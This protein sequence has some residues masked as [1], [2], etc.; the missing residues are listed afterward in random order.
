MNK[1]K[2]FCT[3]ILIMMCVIVNA[4]E[5]FQYGLKAGLNI[6]NYSGEFDF[7]EAEAE[8]QV[9]FH[10]G[11]V[12]EIRLINNLSIQPEV[13]Y[14]KE[15][16]K[17]SNLDEGIDTEFKLDFISIPFMFKY[18]ITNNFQALAGPEYG[19]KL[20]H[21]RDLIRNSRYDTNELDK[22]NDKV[23]VNIGA[24]YKFENLSIY[25]RYRIGTAEVYDIDYVNLKSSGIYI[26]LE[27]FL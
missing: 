13:L 27:Y 9:S 23:S 20:D 10:A 3:T 4:Q 24:S 19:I 8:G 21:D 17:I 11:L 12:T 5:K 16:F 2:F 26:G 22:L 15:N 18:Y 1:Q 7:S 6:S 25:G 14:E